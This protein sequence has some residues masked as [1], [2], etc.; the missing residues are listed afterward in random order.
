MTFGLYV[1]LILKSECRKTFSAMGNFSGLDRHKVALLLPKHEENIDQMRIVGKQAYINICK[2]YC[3][4]DETT[5]WKMYSEIIAGTW[6]IKNT[7]T[8]GLARALQIIVALITDGKTALPIH[9]DFLFPKSLSGEAI[10]TKKA[11]IKT[12]ID[13]VKKMFPD[14]KITFVADGGYSS[15]EIIDLFITENVAFDARFHKNRKVE[16]KGGCQRIDEIK[17]LKLRGRQKQKTILAVWHGHRLWITTLLRTSKNG[18]ES[19]VYLVSTYEAP[20]REHAKA[21]KIR[22]Y[23]EKMFRTSK[24]SLGL[25]DCQSTQGKMQL[26]HISS[27]LLAYAASQLEMKIG[28]F[29]NPENAI[30]SLREANKREFS[31]RMARLNRIFA[32]RY[33]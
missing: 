11:L 14:K 9:C 18:S 7:K 22:W 25:S 4:L 28:R 1:A 10:Y 30:R 24:Q 5:I 23:V 19:I 12:I 3:I 31:A 27:A 6:L 2:L 15:L 26:A 29:K 33:A 13:V 20:P 32:F 16:Y 8:G 17:D 21:Y